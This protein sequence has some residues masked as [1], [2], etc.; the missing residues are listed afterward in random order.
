VAIFISS[1][2]WPR[3][4]ERLSVPTV[5]PKILEPQWF[6]PFFVVLWFSISAL[7]SRVSGWTKLAERFR[8]ANGLDGERFRFASASIGALSWLPVGY[9]G[10]LFFTV[11][12]TGFRMS[13][14]FP[15]RF[16]TPPLFIP[17]AQVEVVTEQTS[18]LAHRVVVRIRGYSSKISVLGHAGK[19]IAHA[20]GRFRSTQA[21]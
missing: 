5:T 21:L 20:Y 9:S 8:A 11:G 16:L 2:R 18:W 12:R 6:F 19:S 14:F 3:T 15:F 4:L 7:V 1:A 13:V 10:C 17:W